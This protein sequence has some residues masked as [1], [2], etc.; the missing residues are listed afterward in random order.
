[1]LPDSPRLYHMLKTADKNPGLM[2][3]AGGVLYALAMAD[4]PLIG[5]MLL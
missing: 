5:E 4:D 1:M 2:Q 3:G